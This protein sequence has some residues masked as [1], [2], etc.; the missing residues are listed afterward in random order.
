MA[1][2]EAGDDGAPGGIDHYRGGPAQRLDRLARAHRGDAIAGN[3]HGLG[4]GLAGAGEDGAVHHDEVGA[5]RLRDSIAPGHVG[6]DRG[7]Q[8]RRHGEP[9][10]PRR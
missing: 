7:S 4:D 8:R 2:V 5:R 6:A 9:D 10:E 1:V 3:R